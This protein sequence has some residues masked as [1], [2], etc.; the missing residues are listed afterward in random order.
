MSLISVQLS[1]LKHIMTEYLTSQNAYLT[2]KKDKLQ[3][4]PMDK[5]R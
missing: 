1:I 3:K 4:Q 2:A 5:L